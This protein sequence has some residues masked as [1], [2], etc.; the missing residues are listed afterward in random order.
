MLRTDLTLSAVGDRPQHVDRVPA[1]AA[2]RDE[3]DP[4]TPRLLAELDHYT[5]SELRALWG[6]R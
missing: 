3:R 1:E 2:I 5:E 6:D 4:L